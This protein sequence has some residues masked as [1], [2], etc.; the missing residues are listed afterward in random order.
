[1]EFEE[2][3]SKDTIPFKYVVYA[4]QFTVFFRK[5]L[6]PC[7]VVHVMA[8]NEFNVLSLKTPLKTF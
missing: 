5:K 7:P 8:Q 2:V 4:V 1:M 6:R 3:Q